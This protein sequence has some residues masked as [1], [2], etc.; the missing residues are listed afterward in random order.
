MTRQ[1]GTTLRNS[2][3]QDYEDEIGTSPKVR[4][5]SGTMPA[6]CAASAG[7]QLCELTN[8]TSNWRAAPSGGS[9]ALA[10]TF[11]GTVAADGD[12]THYRVYA[13]DGTTCHEQGTITRAFPLTT[14]DPTSSPSN[15]LTFADT[16][17]VTTGMSV[18]GTGIPA[19]A[20][21]A[22]V[23]ST[24]VSLSA[25]VEAGGVA[26]NAVIYFGD[27]SGKLYMQTTALTIGMNLTLSQWDRTAPGA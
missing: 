4:I 16:T 19:G 10:G 21:V 27:T 7:T 23:T 12:A 25:P 1:Y 9:S 2:L 3:L 13:S 17:G 11:T 20:T 22:G 24:T 5:Y 26:D 6:N 15:V 14:T 18:T 8:A